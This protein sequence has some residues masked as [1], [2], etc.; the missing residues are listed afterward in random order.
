MLGKHPQGDPTIPLHHAELFPV[1]DARPSLPGHHDLGEKRIGNADSLMT[2]VQIKACLSLWDKMQGWKPGELTTPVPNDCN[3][4][5]FSLLGFHQVYD[6][7][8]KDYFKSHGEKMV[9]LPCYSALISYRIHFRYY[10]GKKIPVSEIRDTRLLKERIFVESIQDP[11]KAILSAQRLM[12]LTQGSEDASKLLLSSSIAQA[13]AR[14]IPAGDP[15][16]RELADVASALKERV[17]QESDEMLEATALSSV[18]GAR[19]LDQAKTEALQF[20]QKWE[21]PGIGFYYLSRRESDR[22]QN[23]RAAYYMRQALEREPGQIKYS[24]LLTQLEHPSARRVSF[25]YLVPLDLDE[26]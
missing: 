17:A 1:K 11:T 9:S 4:V 19:T 10:L 24:S 20:A 21:R 3:K 22:G 16:W 15:R 7:D 23:D 5:P 12:E 6:R 18:Y 25:P 8:C 14:Q 13:Y 26:P 2:E